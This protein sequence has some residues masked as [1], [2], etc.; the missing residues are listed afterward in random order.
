MADTRTW[1]G[2][3]T[4]GRYAAIATD[5]THGTVPDGGPYHAGESGGAE[6]PLIGRGVELATGLARLAQPGIRL[7]ALTGS[8]GVGKTRLARAIAQEAR[9]QYGWE[10]YFLDVSLLA[11]GDALLARLA[12]KSAPRKGVNG[13]ASAAPGFDRA[14][15]LSTSVDLLILD[16]CDRVAGLDGAIVALLEHFPALKILSTSSASYRSPRQHAYPLLPLE[17]PDPRRRA[18][19]ESIQAIPA[20]AFFVER[21][22]MLNPEFVLTAQNAVAIAELC[23]RL[24]GLP[25]ALE[26]AAAR[27]K[28]LTPVA[29]LEHLV[30]GE[31]HWIG[32]LD[33]TLLA[34]SEGNSCEP[35]LDLIASYRASYE[36]LPEGDR[37][38][39]AQLAVCSDGFDLEL[40]EAIW[41]MPRDARVA[42][43]RRLELFG[44]L[45]LLTRQPASDGQPRFRLLA[46]LREFLL[47][48]LRDEGELLET[49]RRHANALLALAEQAATHLQTQISERWLARLDAEY[50]NCRV[51]LRWFREAGHLVEGLRLGSA[52]WRFWWHRGY[53]GEGRQELQALLDADS[54]GA[55]ADI[56]A[57]ALSAAGNLSTKQGDYLHA[58]AFLLE[59]L[60]L[61]RTRPGAEMVIAVALDDLGFVQYRQNLHE[62]A[63]TSFEESLFLARQTEFDRGAGRALNHL[64]LLLL[65]MG[66]P[67]E[68][69]QLFEEAQALFG[70]VADTLNVAMSL[71]YLGAAWL[72]AG[73]LTLGKTWF[74]QAL[75]YAAEHGIRRA[76]VMA[77]AG[78]GEIA[79]ARED[80]ARVRDCYA[81]SLLVASEDADY[82]GVVNGI[83][84]LAALAAALGEVVA[85]LRLAAAAEH[86]RATLGAPALPIESARFARRLGRARRA[87]SDDRGK[88]LQI[89]GSR[90]T[91]EQAIEQAFLVGESVPTPVEDAVLRDIG[92]GLKPGD[93]LTPREWEVAQL[94][95]RGQTNRQ[96]ADALSI[97]ERTAS[98]H[99]SHILGKLALTSRTQIAAWTRTAQPAEHTG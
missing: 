86:L 44:D 10:T 28:V 3:L 52:L 68:A 31:V 69:R 22:R 72:A 93:E 81:A 30:Q 18:S 17:I 4:V 36:L 99:V 39:L 49:G 60:R 42:T 95:A 79:F 67:Q 19:P 24:D 34:R 58:H 71:C 14:E 51:A 9:L 23:I 1:T 62:Q 98:T 85:A 16:E 92:G 91:I 74:D 15:Y 88:A 12:P 48:Q 64:G 25:L 53:L 83:E 5:T 59:C 32:Q 54:G 13:A 90:L 29:L 37:I 6:T 7:L 47:E 61:Q 94:I 78:Q 11:E 45:G 8:P 96:V 63:R 97:T 50:G 57:A 55:P 76:K 70:T 20:V 89:E 73:E 80:Y 38:A 46:T 2:N 40:I 75:L 33:L 27:L 41:C 26:C 66:E 87:C 43:L 77:L 35:Q 84:G 82:Q 21:A 65:D 56:R